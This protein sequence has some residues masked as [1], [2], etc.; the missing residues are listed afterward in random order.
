MKRILTL[1]LCAVLMLGATV[2][3]AQ[4]GFHHKRGP[5]GPGEPG[6]REEFLARALDLTDEQKAAAN[7][8]HEQV[9]AKA[10]PLM[11]QNRAQR[12]EIRALLDGANPDA[13]EIGRKMIAAHATG[14]QLKALH[15]EAMTRISALLNAQQLEK[16]KK[17]QEMRDDHEGFGPPGPGF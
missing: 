1:A 4:P 9:R 13:T 10:E 8:I 17:L 7:T 2:L 11:E 5:G 6:G 3:F 16:F 14:E 15:D 12:D